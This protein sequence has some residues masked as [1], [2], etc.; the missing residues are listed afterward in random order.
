MTG[1]NLDHLDRLILNA[2]QSDFPVAVRPYAALAETLNAAHGLNLTEAEVHGRIRALRRDGF[3]RRL[4]AVFNARA[5]GYR[6]TLCAA[7]VPADRLEIFR[8]LADRAPQITH[9]YLRSDELNAW[10]TFT[11]N[12]PEELGDFLKLL[13]EAGGLEKIHIL[14]ADNIFKIKVDFQFA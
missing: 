10:F 3:I 11:T 5:L 7:R 14:D 8:D 9:N 13:R 6:S 1:R 12:R 4:G 2:A